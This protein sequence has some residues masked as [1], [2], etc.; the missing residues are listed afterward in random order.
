MMSA[1]GAGGPGS[2]VSGGLCSQP[3]E[4]REQ[5]RRRLAGSR[6]RLAGDVLAVER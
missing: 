4:Q 2:V 3:M 1:R 6:L 5:E